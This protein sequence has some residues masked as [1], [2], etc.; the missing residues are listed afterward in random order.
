MLFKSRMAVFKR[1]SHERPLQMAVKSRVS[2]FR[3]PRHPQP[4]FGAIKSRTGNHYGMSHGN[5]LIAGRGDGILTV[6]GEPAE[7]RILLFDRDTF[8]LVR[9]VWSN[10]NG[11]YLF[12]RINPDREYLVLAIDHKKQYEPVAYDFVRPAVPESG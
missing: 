4:L 2:G 11:T 9:S 6:G 10:P 7:R 12:D 1:P 5:G 8:K 3:R